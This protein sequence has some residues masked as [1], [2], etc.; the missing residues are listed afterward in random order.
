MT[1]NESFKRR[2]RERMELTGERY[3]TARAALLARAERMNEQRERSWVSEPELNEESIRRGT[4][5]GWEHWCSLIESWAVDPWD[6]ALVAARL[7]AETGLNGWY[8]QGITVGYERITGIRLPHQM[9]DGT[10]TANKSRTIPIDAAELRAALLDDDERHDLFPGESTRLRSRPTSKAVRVE[11]GPGIAGF[12]LEERA[13]G[14][15]KVTVSHEK[16]PTVDDVDRWKFWWDEWLDA[17]AD[18]GDGTE[19]DAGADPG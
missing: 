16:L 8:S 19:A 12:A 7:L 9:L 5:H 10:F 18:G 3:T 13:D 14:R 11:I 2:I 1:S 17:L 15:T 4:G 6:H